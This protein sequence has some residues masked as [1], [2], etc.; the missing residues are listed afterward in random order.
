MHVELGKRRGAP[1]RGGGGR[2]GGSGGGGAEQLVRIERGEDDVEELDKE[3]KEDLETGKYM[4][5]TETEGETEGRSQR[6]D[7]EKG[8]SLC[9][10]H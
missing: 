7:G 6:D 8:R 2:G 5:E 10:I 1:A 4:K 9:D 3:Q